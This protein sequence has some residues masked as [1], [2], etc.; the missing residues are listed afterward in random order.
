MAVTVGAICDGI[1]ETL[2]T[3]ASI[4]SSTS[5][6]EMTEGV[7][8]FDTPRLEVYPNNGTCDPSGS[9]D[10]TAFQANVQQSY[11][12]FFAN[13]LVRQR[14]QLDEDMGAVVVMVDELIPILEAQERPPFFG[15]EGIKALT[16]SWRVAT[17]TR[18]KARY[19]GVRFTIR[20]KI[21]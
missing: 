12:T 1:L 4:K 16:W 15:V 11:V 20:C 5:Y 14:S 17:F 7:S 19:V 10:R 3:A 8:V 2:G 18:S 9:T 13:V 21:F 6:N